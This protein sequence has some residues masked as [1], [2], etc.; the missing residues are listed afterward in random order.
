M[1]IVIS[2]S[3]WFSGRES[4]CQCQRHRRCGFD[5]WVE[6]IPWSRNWQPITAILPGESHGHRSLMGYSPWDHKELDTTWRLSTQ[7]LLCARPCLNYSLYLVTHSVL[8]TISLFFK[9]KIEAQN[10]RDYIKDSY[11]IL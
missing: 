4:P 8:T 9:L 6:K 1:I 11:W 5:P 10:K 3:P 7:D 2:S